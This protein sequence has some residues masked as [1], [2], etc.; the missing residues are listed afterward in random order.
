MKWIAWV[1]LAAAT[2]TGSAATPELE[3]PTLSVAVNSYIERASEHPGQQCIC[4]DKS[5]LEIEWVEQNIRL[6]G[7]KAGHTLCGFTRQ[8]GGKPIANLIF[9]ITV[10]E[11]RKLA[12]QK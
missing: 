7:K 2:T 1:F 5:L 11:P 3:Y 4:D 8:V 9:D 6:T 10:T 12:K